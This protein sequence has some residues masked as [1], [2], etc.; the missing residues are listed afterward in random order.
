M[1]QANYQE[2]I[3]ETFSMDRESVEK[4]SRKILES[5]DGSKMC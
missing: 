1:D 4:L 3:E 2:A 5:Y